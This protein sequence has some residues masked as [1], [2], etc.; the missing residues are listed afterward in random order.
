ML[1]ARPLL[2]PSLLRPALL[3]LR[4]PPSTLACTSKSKPPKFLPARPRPFSSRPPK[5]PPPPPAEQPITQA[6]RIS[7]LHAHLSVAH[8]IDPSLLSLSEVTSVGPEAYKTYTTYIAPKRDKLDGFLNNSTLL[9]AEKHAERA[10]NQIAFLYKKHLAATS[11]SIRNVDVPLAPSSAPS[12]R[13]PIVLLLDSLRS[14]QNVG[15]LLRSSDAAG[16]T[17]VVTTGITPHIGGAGGP[18]VLKVSLGAERSVPYR[19][20]PS[21][22]DAVRELR[23]RGYKIVCLETAEEAVGLYEVDWGGWI[24][25]SAGVAL[26]LGN[27]VSGVDPLL[28]AAEEL[29]DGIVE[30]PMHGA[31]NSLNVAVA[32]PLAM[33]EIVRCLSHDEDGGRSY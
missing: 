25:G 14:A 8:S 3:S 31:K 13:H 19:H 33:F 20:V 28:L 30:I 27:E 29:I 32:G 5:P 9:D 7:L 10:S 11:P 26:V 4:P 2:R 24:E 1:P 6:L 17:E 23:G 22:F 12:T 15:S 16:L 18:K 21:L